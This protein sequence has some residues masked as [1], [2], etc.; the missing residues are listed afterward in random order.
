MLFIVTMS[1]R[2]VTVVMILMLNCKLLRDESG[3]IVA[4]SL[5]FP[6]EDGSI[7]IS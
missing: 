6:A 5:T 1:M 3:W 4:L 7:L 2:V